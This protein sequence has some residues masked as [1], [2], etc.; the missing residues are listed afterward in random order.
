MTQRLRCQGGGNLVFDSTCTFIAGAWVNGGFV[1][2]IGDGCSSTLNCSLKF[3]AYNPTVS[4]GGTLT[5]APKTFDYYSSQKASFV[6]ESYGL[7][8]IPNGLTLAHANAN[9]T[10]AFNL[11]SGGEIALGG[12]LDMLNDD[13]TC[14]FTIAGGTISATG[15]VSFAHFDTLQATGSFVANVEQNGLLDLSGYTFGQDVSITKTGDGSVVL[16]TTGATATISAGSVALNA[17]PYDF[18]G[19][20][21]GSGTVVELAAL[22]ATVNSFDNTLKTAPTFVANLSGA[23]VGSTV[24]SSSDADLLA[25]VKADL[26]GDSEFPGDKQL[27][28]SGTAL[29]FENKASAYSFG[30]NGDLDILDIAGWGGSVPGDGESVSITGAT[31]VATFSVGDFPKWNSI[32][33]KDG[34][35]LRIS[36]DAD[37]PMI[38]LYPNAALEISSGT[39]CL[40][41]GFAG[42]YEIV[43]ETVHLPI[44][45]VAT[46]A[47]LQIA[48]GM[49]FKDVDIRLYGKVTKA[50]DGEASP[51]FGHADNGET[52]Y[53]ALTADGGVFDFHS[54]QVIANG[55]VSIVCP[56]SGGT[57]IPVGTITLRNSSRTVNGWADFGNWEFG[58]N[59]PTSVPFDVLVDGTVLDCSSYFYASGAAHLS[60]VNGACIQ[61]NSSCLGHYFSQAIQDS[62]T[63]DIGE[64]CYLDFTTGD[65]KFGIDSQSAVDTVTV[66]DGGAYTVSY[67]SSGWG[68]GVF[69]S[70]GGA[71]GV[72]KLNLNKDTVRQR[73]DLLLGFGSARLDGN[74]SIASVNMGTGNYDWDRHTTMANIP[75][76]GTGNVT[77]TN[78]VPAYPFTVTMV[79]GANTATGTIKVAKVEGDAET[80]LYFANGANWAG[81]V[82]ADGNVALT[83]LV[84]AAAAV[85]NTFGTL[86]LDADFPIRVWK[87]GD[88]IVND[89]LNVGAYVNNGGKLVL[90]GD[91][92]APGDTLILGTL[93]DANALPDVKGNWKMSVVDGKLQL[94]YQSGLSIIFR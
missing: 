80:K 14:S 27:T 59:N 55:S 8:K 44:L 51:V 81:T 7:T 58:V 29:K 87:S 38:T 71:L 42:S 49:K 37:L 52:T 79:N 46:N 83:N 16:P 63:V 82:V 50:S 85:T 72:T 47:T 36:A 84:D 73:T 11:Y 3:Y 90:V 74:L 76:S 70:D 60:L 23:V 9:T 2:T 62:A 40:T 68:L 20:T 18:S 21:F 69:A 33:V 22:G 1:H 75:F 35:R 93:A 32:E 88:T 15:T 6:L 91:A 61:R 89:A 45:S 4:S 57:V 43:G 10:V 41:N 39:T 92:L 28:I 54:N 78:G 17:A 94:K 19:V 67:N 5:L 66:R 26:E 24:F 53:I 25:K 31:T 65:G 12:P 64:G 48:A 34:A 13:G 30:A 77:I 86:R 56:A